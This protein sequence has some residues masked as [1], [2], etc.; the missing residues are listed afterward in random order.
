MA[1]EVTY[2]GYRWV[3]LGLAW[4]LNFMVGMNHVIIA[5]RAHDII[6]QLGLT[7]SQFYMAYTAVAILPIV[8]CMVGGTLADRFGVKWTL[9][10]GAAIATAAALLRLTATGF[11]PFFLFMAL[12]G[13]GYGVVFPVRAKLVAVWFPAKQ[14]AIA[15]GIYMT[16]AVGTAIALFVGP[17]FGSWQAAVIV[18]GILMAV[19]TVL[20]FILARERPVE[21][22]GVRVLG[23]PFREGLAVAAKSKNMWWTGVSYFFTVG[24]IMA[25]IGGLPHFLEVSKGMSPS[26]ASMIP[27]LSVLGF[28]VGTLFWPILS[29]KVG[30]I[31]PFYMV[32][33]VMTGLTGVL[34]YYTAPGI[35]CW[36]FGVLPGFFAGAGPALIMQLP[37]HLPEFGPRYAGNAGGLLFSVYHVGSFVLLPFMFT[38]IWNTFG[39][40][41]AA[42]FLAGSLIVAAALFVP[43]LEVGRKARE[44][45][46]KQ[47]VEAVEAP[48]A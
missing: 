46:E 11:W 29:E 3:M 20:W 34:V 17:A 47:L 4:I 33:V 19:A 6:P 15:T 48:M 10:A 27:A 14:V 32:G 18:M 2:P 37:I 7:T 9:G 23:V 39:A 36:V 31:K 28:L 38:P 1:E 40:Y 21:V 30:V 43:V 41:P 12:L 45:R 8:M 22:A 35:L 16:G 13:V 44:A 25:W 5:T 26:A 24:V 42:W